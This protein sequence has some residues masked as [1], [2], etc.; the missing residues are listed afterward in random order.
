MQ[1]VVCIHE[2]NLNHIAFSSVKMHQH[3]TLQQIVRE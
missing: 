1:A 3:L 2:Q